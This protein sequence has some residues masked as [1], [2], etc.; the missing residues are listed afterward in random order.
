MGAGTLAGGLQTPP[1]TA[2][3]WSEAESVG[4]ARTF[5]HHAGAGCG[6]GAV[7]PIGLAVAPTYRVVLLSAQLGARLA[8]GA[9]IGR[10]AVLADNVGAVLGRAAAIACP[11]T[12]QLFFGTR[13]FRTRPA[14]IRTG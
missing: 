13:A 9:G 14:A 5:A 3:C 7:V 4:R 12:T 10:S 2:V 11:A 1:G 6:R 8:G